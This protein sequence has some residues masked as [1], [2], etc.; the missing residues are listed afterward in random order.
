M[1]RCEIG[2]EY[3]DVPTTNKANSYFSKSTQWFLS[4]R[5]ALKAIVSDLKQLNTVAMPSWCC[6]SMIKPFIDAGF[7][8]HF[9]PVYFDGGLIQEIEMVCDVLFLMDYFGYSTQA[10]D[11]QNYKGIVI[12]DITHSVFSKY[13]TDA[14][15]YFG[16]LR[17]W[18]GVCTGG[19]A[20]TRDGHRLESGANDGQEYVVLRKRAMDE[21]NEYIKG[22][23]EDKDYLKAFDEA[24]E[25]LEGVGIVPAID[26]DVEL[27]QRLDVEIIKVRR[28][29]NASILRS[30]FLE[31]LIFPNL[32]PTDTPMFV[33]VQVPNG[34]RDALR[35]YLIQKE[36]YCPIHWPVGEYHKLDERTALIYENELSLVCDQRYTEKDMK[37]IVDTIKQFEKE[38]E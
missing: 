17:K 24:E 14:D 7:S 15:Y 25:L 21:K 36:I 28:R 2:S 33:P 9:Y 4:G 16:S 19:Y 37:R 30:A 38:E 20:W 1:K 23:R 18:C 10:F 26:R 5:S 12:R 13:Y 27:A 35:R 31:W 8:V 32:D 29:T 6:D 34:K 11:L 22:E 3:W